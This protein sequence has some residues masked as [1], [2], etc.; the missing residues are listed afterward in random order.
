M[1]ILIRGLFI[2]QT[3]EYFKVYLCWTVSGF[4]GPV[5]P[6]VTLADTC[7]NIEKHCPTLPS[8]VKS[9]AKLIN[10]AETGKDW[11]ALARELGECPRQCRILVL[12]KISKVHSCI[13][14]E[15]TLLIESTVI[16]YLFPV[17]NRKMSDVKSKYIL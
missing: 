8:W 12:Y 10:S 17:N 6:Q 11:T 15:E 7:G 14:L 16:D 4:N 2:S 3:H 1:Y 13:N 9:A 5:L